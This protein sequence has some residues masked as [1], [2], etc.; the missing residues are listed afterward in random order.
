M[1]TSKD[2]ESRTI[3]AEEERTYSRA[4]FVENLKD[5][6]AQ[7]DTPQYIIAKAAGVSK[8]QVSHWLKGMYTPRMPAIDRL[9]YEFNLP[10]SYF[11]E[12][13]HGH[14]LH[15]NETKSSGIIPVLM[16]P[17]KLSLLFTR[18][19][20]NLTRSAVRSSLT[21]SMTFSKTR[22]TQNEKET[23]R[24]IHQISYD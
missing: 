11:L 14:D 4:V 15:K 3:E 18:L 17:L 5:F 6:M 1:A 13:N 22:S 10:R 8:G 19:P 16:F 24:Q 2:I 23:R 20:N 7:N 9:C 12:K 21:I